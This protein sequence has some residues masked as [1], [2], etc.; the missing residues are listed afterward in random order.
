MDYLAWKWEQPCSGVVYSW[1]TRII[2]SMHSLYWTVLQV[3]A[4]TLALQAHIDLP[5]SRLISSPSSYEFRIFYCARN[6]ME[7]SRTYEHGS[8]L[9]QMALIWSCKAWPSL[10]T[11]AGAQYSS[12]AFVILFSFTFQA[13]L[14][15]NSGF[16]WRF[17]FLLTSRSFCFYSFATKPPHLGQFWALMQRGTYQKW[18]SRFFPIYSRGVSWSPSLTNCCY[19]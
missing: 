11:F 5:Y 4:P 16:Y 19:R 13:F 2:D 15:S 7:E 18:A 17:H 3:Y 12:K 9:V 14:A 1:R 6:L 8:C 10:V